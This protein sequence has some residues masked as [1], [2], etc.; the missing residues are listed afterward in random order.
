MK[1][2]ISLAAVL[3]RIDR[4]KTR[5]TMPI[6]L[7]VMA[8]LVFC[9]YRYNVDLLG[10]ISNPDTSPEVA[11]ALSQRG[12]LLAAFGI[13]WALFR[14]L[15]FK[16]RNAL[17]GLLFLAVLTAGGYFALDA[18]YEKAIDSLPPNIKVMGYNLLLYRHD[19]LTGD[20]E[21]PD[22]PSVKEEPVEGK[23]FMGAFPMVLLDDRFMVPAQAYVIRRADLKVEESLQL[24]EE[25][26]PQ[27]EK[28]MADIDAGYEKFIAWSKKAAGDEL[29][30]E[31]GRYALQ[32]QKLDEAFQH[33]RQARDM[34]V[35]K[36]D[37]TEEW[38]AYDTQMNVLRA[39]HEEFVDGSRKVAQYAGG[40]R[41]AEARRRFRAASGG[42][43][44][45]A[46][47][48]L[49]DFPEL[50]K[51]S[52]HGKKIIAGENRVIGHDPYGSPILA[53]EIP[54]FLDRPGLEGWI[55]ERAARGLRSVD[56]PMNKEMTHEEFL[57]WLR[58][59]PTPGG[60]SLRAHEAR[61]YGPSEHPVLGRDIPY[62]MDRA[63]FIRWTR[64]KAQETLLA[65]DMPPD[66]GLSREGFL[67]LLRKAKNKEGEQLRTA[68]NRL[69]VALPDGTRLKIGDVPYFMDRETYLQWANDE[70]E[71][72]KV[73][74]VP[75][76][77]NV[78]EFATINQSNAAVF[79]P[80][81]AIISSLTSALVNA[82][83]LL[84]LLI[85]SGLALSPATRKAGALIGKLSVPLMLA[86][87]L[88]LIFA[89]PPH[90]F[91]PDT[92][93]WNLESKFHEQIGIPA[94][95]WSRL[96]NVQKL[97]L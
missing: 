13:T 43:E 29:I 7:L 9:E 44:P 79:V 27:Y 63:D 23:I 30:Q 71:R 8:I 55:A 68:E 14:N 64:H 39:K 86:C 58:K 66:P 22:I 78:D 84:I 31:W 21:D 32:M 49:E 69:L 56:L 88:A 26:W 80:P 73:K 59:S 11:E 19:L 53:K 90:V 60:D 37:L 74:L 93:A 25:K 52:S 97:F 18:L 20:L 94:Q 96:S 35:G 16:F 17:F 33:Y 36:A 62:F 77:E 54:Y 76:E 28:N 34:A 92:E 47:V 95:L 24:A 5:F 85:A 89:M 46:R 57:A 75:T 70:V 50:L 72:L 61:N 38:K 3:E 87:F 82:L 45:N 41:E 83:S 65:Y 51:R 6:M 91:R 40:K 2:R 15:A 4:A 48:S 12:K 67:D 1:N 81:M 42:L 10:S